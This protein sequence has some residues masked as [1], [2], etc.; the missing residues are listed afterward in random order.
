MKITYSI[1]QYDEDGD[2]FD[3]CILININ[4]STILRFKNIDELAD[5]FRQFDKCM[6]EMTRYSSTNN[7]L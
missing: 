6:R 7:L 5:F 2:I 4:D 3:K 1:N